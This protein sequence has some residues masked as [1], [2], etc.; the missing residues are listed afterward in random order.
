MRRRLAGPAS[1]RGPRPHPFEERVN[2]GF[3]LVLLV[4]VDVHDRIVGR[5]LAQ[6]QCMS[7]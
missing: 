5:S 7:R 3:A 6:P 1:P 4:A 2:T